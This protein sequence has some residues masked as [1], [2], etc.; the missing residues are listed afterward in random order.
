MSLRGVY[1][2]IYSW[3]GEAVFW[4]S[5]IQIHEVHQH[6][7]FPVCFLYQDNIGQ[8]VWVVDFLDKI[9]CKQF[10][11]LVYDDF[12]SF[13]GKDSS[14]L[15][16]GLFLWVYIQMVLDD[17]GCYACHVFMT[18]HE[19][20]QIAPKEL[21]QPLLHLSA[22]VCPYLHRLRQFPVYQLHGF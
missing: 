3:Q 17:F 19:N 6:P 10:V 18:P 14:S 2:L 9:G 8:P 11:Y 21:D 12:V 13:K 4:A 7:P 16:D 1:Q 20:V 22:Q 5:L 15:L